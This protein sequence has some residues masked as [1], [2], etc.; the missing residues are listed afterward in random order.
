[1]NFDRSLIF[2]YLEEDNI[3]RAYFRVRPLL[4]LEGDVR[5]E[6][7]QLWPNEG[8]L[9][10]VPDRNEQHTFK[11]RMRTLGAYCVV[12]LR[13]QPTEA[14]KIRTNKNFKP[15]RGEVNQ[16]ILYSDTVR[17]L[18]ENTFYQLVDGTA[19]DYAAL[20]EQAVTPLFFIREG[21]TIYGPVTKKTP[22]QP[23]TAPESAGML[24][25]LPCPDGA[26]RM[27]LCMDDGPAAEVSGQPEAAKPEEEAS[28]E[29]SDAP[30]ENA[31]DVPAP[32]KA[33][34]PEAAEKQDEALP[35]GEALQI[36]DETKTTEDTLK[37][38]DKPVSAGAN[39]LKQK[40]VKNVEKPAPA[41][42]EGLSGTPL[43]RTPL[44]V[45]VQQNKNR[46]QE[47]VNN[48]WSVGKYEPPTQNL[49]AGAALR[50]VQNPVEAACSQ[51]RQA[52]NASSAHDQLT[53]F[54]LSL[55]GI[56]SKLEAK[57]CK[58]SNVTIMQRVLRERLQDLEAERLTALCELDKARRDVDAYKQELITGLS[59]RIARE[60]GKLEEN[61]KQAEADVASL[62]TEINSLSIQRDALLA[63]VNEL[64]AN[65]LP[66]TVAKL[67]ADAQ[68]LAPAAGIPLRLTPVSGEDVEL[69]ALIDRLTGACTASGV[70]IARNT[71]IALLVLLAVSTRIGIACST[72]ASAATL[73]KNIAG[74]MGWQQSYAHQIAAE[75]RPVAGIRPVDATPAILTTSLSNYAPI[76]GV[77]KL[78][79]NRNASN[80]VRNAAYDV[81]SWPI[82]MVSALPFVAECE[83]MDATPISEASI[84]RIA[85][86]KAAD[87]KEIDAVLSPVLKAAPPLSGA[88]R[89]ELYQFVSV[90]AGLM[91][92]GLP[93]AVDWGIL[94][95]IVPALERGSKHYNAVKALLDE[96]PL[97]LAKL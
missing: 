29:K 78:V 14:G 68:M 51:L 62:K 39:L 21:D 4:T 79:M 5:Q 36:L 32:E 7:I 26:T 27:M 83:T 74:A 77:I 25:E 17:E 11:N 45:S 76:N 73:M 57:L 66:E 2:A 70:E 65:V 87:P 52:W 44:H 13:N 28:A 90:C 75:Q 88:A 71:A 24:Y 38:L 93:V 56:R 9:R 6:A 10:I 94:L 89:N 95:W 97:S 85:E 72:P 59:A 43:V 54:M 91:E 1:M 53:D 63:K 37:Q 23:E 67:I 19:A 69:D 30:A 61:K 60:T 86:K 80:L 40:E 12:D 49:P 84:R 50:S 58:G 48:Q 8:G 15:E 20:A 47:I 22:A 41:Q 92:G 64:Q 33:E 81:S 42:V 34:E 16:F 55:D 18:P 3:Q 96:Y 46:T 35:I 31:A 82:L